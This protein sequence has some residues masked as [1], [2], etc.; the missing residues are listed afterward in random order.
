MKMNTLVLFQMISGLIQQ[1]ARHIYMTLVNTSTFLDSVHVLAFYVLLQTQ[2]WDTFRFVI[3]QTYSFWFCQ[4]KIPV[5]SEEFLQDA[6][7][8][9][10]VLNAQESDMNVGIVV[11]I[12]LYLL[13]C[14]VGH[15]I[16]LQPCKT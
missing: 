9:V 16:Q 12:F 7:H 3:M 10:D 13:S 2:I 1:Y 15:S 11:F 14:S 6:L 5:P 8:P 4:R